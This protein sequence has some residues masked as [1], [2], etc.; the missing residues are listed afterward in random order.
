MMGVTNVL[1]WEAYRKES[2]HFLHPISICYEW[3]NDWFCVIHHKMYSQ[4]TFVMA[5]ADQEHYCSPEVFC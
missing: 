1:S 5:L 3:N 2:N 4:S